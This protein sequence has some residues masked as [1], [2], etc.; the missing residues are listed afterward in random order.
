[1]ETLKEFH[2]IIF[3]HSI[4]VYTN[5]NNLI[6]DKHITERVLRWRLLLEYYVPNIKSIKGSDTDEAEALIRLPLLKYVVK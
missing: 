4:T 6:Y 1:M 2:K 5:H 3:G